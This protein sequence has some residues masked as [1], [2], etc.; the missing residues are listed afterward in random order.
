MESF[1]QRKWQ[2]FKKLL[3][4]KLQSSTLPQDSNEH[5]SHINTVI[6]NAA[7]ETIG[8][9]RTFVAKPWWN[10]EQM[11]SKQQQKLRQN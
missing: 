11:N 8:F 6:Y 3:S 1:L 4:T 2:K 10:L 5:A 9:D 7:V